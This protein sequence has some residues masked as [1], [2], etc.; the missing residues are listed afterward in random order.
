MA[1]TLNIAVVGL[2]FGG[3]YIPALC[4]HPSVGEIGLC[5]LNEETLR[6]VSE[7]HG[8][9]KIC[10]YRNLDEVIGS[11]R[12]DAVMLLSPIPFHADQSVAVFE[13]GL[14]CAC[15][16]P[17]ATTALDCERVAAAR[18][19]SGR[20][21]TLLETSLCTNE[22][23]FLQDMLR[24]GELGDIQFMR[25]VWYNHLDQ[26][27]KWWHGLPP[28]HYIT[29]PLAPML[30]LAGRTVK[31]VSCYGSGTLPPGFEKG[32]GNPFPVET[33]IF[34]LGEESL[35]V[36]FPVYGDQ[37]RPLAI[38]V[39]SITANTALQNKETFDVFC[40]K[41]SFFWATHPG[42]EHALVRRT[43]NEPKFADKSNPAVMMKFRSP[44]I[45]TDIPDALRN[46]SSW[47]PQTNLV[48]EFVT[49]CLEQRPSLYDI[50]AA[51]AFSLPG[52]LAHDAAMRAR[53]ESSAAEQKENK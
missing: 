17:M 8:I 27:P 7:K 13:A 52:I 51:K 23:Y 48:H 1:D 19:K 16:V 32:Y 35:S 46:L 39:T 11:H 33:A 50:D 18:K 41:H 34:E 49:A 5:D 6:A 40:S 28:M 47:T 36:D 26:H 9:A 22:F 14:H 24:R 44:N 45:R 12:F 3:G 29:H 43:L 53:K 20:T 30:A 38:E 2:S 31:K 4:A 15:T 42:D 21:Y 25:G 37:K 10:R